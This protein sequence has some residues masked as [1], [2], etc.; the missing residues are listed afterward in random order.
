MTLSLGGAISL[1]VVVL[2]MLLFVKGRD[3][4]P[5]WNFETPQ[6]DVLANS[7]YGGAAPVFQEAM[8][9][10]VQVLAGPPLPATGL[11]AGWTMEQWRHYGQNYLDG[12]LQ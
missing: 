5:E 1:L 12:K 8:H 10:N 11:P 6:L 7:A 2:V 3:S 9:Q 4:E